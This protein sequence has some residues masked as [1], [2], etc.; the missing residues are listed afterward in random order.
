MGKYQKEM[1]SNFMDERSFEIH[2]SALEEKGLLLPAEIERIRRRVQGEE[3]RAWLYFILL[4]VGITLVG[5]GL[6]LLIASQWDSFSFITRI[7]V[8]CIP[9]LIASV[10]S[11][12]V[13]KQKNEDWAWSEFT[14]LAWILT[15]GVALILIAQTYQLQGDGGWLLWW[16]ALAGWIAVVAL[17]SATGALINSFISVYAVVQLISGIRPESG[18]LVTLPLVLL[19]F[20]FLIARFSSLAPWRQ[21]VVVFAMSIASI[22]IGVSS[23]QGGPQ[24]NAHLPYWILLIG[25]TSIM[26][27]IV[28]TYGSRFIYTLRTLFSILSGILLLGTTQLFQSQTGTWFPQPMQWTWQTIPNLI[29]QLVIVLSPSI[30]YLFN[31]KTWDT[32]KIMVSLLP[33]LSWIGWGVGGILGAIVLNVSV[34]GLAGVGILHGY[35]TRTLSTLN[36][37]VIL[38]IGLCLFRFFDYEWSFLARGIAFITA[39]ICFLTLN[40]YTRRFFNGKLV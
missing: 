5:G 24:S 36:A 9:W 23:A 31:L 30:V 38:F 33:V 35:C 32:W 10:I 12:W 14:S 4:G 22:F 28:G 11:V 25:M 39:G 17:P 19:G 16:W 18:L 27:I 15:I 13:W 6:I 1:V 7:V 2:L 8:A 20:I 3:P 34:I 21:G 29:I 40:V 37:G 26:T